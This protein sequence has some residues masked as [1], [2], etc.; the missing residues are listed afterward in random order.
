M[1]MEK[2]LVTTKIIVSQKDFLKNETLYSDDRILDSFT[3]RALYTTECLF[4]R[5]FSRLNPD[6]TGVVLSTRTGVYKSIEEAAEAIIEKG[7]R[8]M[9]P[10]RFPNV[11]LSTALARLTIL[12]N[13]HGPCCVFYDEEDYVRDAMEYCK[14]Q[15]RSG[16]SEA[17]IL[18]CTDETGNSEGYFIREEEIV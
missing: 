9:N 15:I 11:M 5:D 6:R 14:L 2:E 3:K 12:C 16:N 10:S 18:I 1:N 17:M 13:V 7:Y 4:Q 8:G